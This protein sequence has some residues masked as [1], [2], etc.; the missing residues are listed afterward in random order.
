MLLICSKFI[1]SLFHIIVR[2]LI[3]EYDLKV[4]VKSTEVGK[5]DK[6]LNIRF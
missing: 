2:G 3:K 1:C 6:I 5:P 4:G